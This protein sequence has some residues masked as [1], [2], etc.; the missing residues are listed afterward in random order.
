MLGRLGGVGDKRVKPQNIRL[1]GPNKGFGQVRD[2]K[3]ALGPMTSHVKKKKKLLPT[4][5]L[6]AHLTLCP[7]IHKVMI[8]SNFSQ[9]S[10]TTAGMPTAKCHE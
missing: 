6:E 4:N 9:G 5:G 1:Q 7:R 10:C 8:L 2:P 3:W